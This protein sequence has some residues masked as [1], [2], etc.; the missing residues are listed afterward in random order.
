M[1]SVLTSPPACQ[2][3]EADFFQAVVSAATGRIDPRLV[4]GYQAAAPGVRTDVDSLGGFLAPNTFTDR[5]ITKAYNTGEILKRCLEL[6]TAGRNKVF[7]PVISE[8]SR[9]NG[10]RFGGMT[11]YRVDEAGTFSDSKPAVGGQWRVLHK[12]AGLIYA[13]NEMLEDYP[14]LLPGYLEFVAGSELAYRAE[15]DIVNGDGAA[16]A[17][18][19]I[20]APCRI[21]I[22]KETNQPAATVQGENISKMLARFW[23]PSQRKGVWLYN[24][25]LLPTLSQLV[26]EAGYGS[27]TVAV[28]APL[29]NWDGNAKS[30]GWPT[31]A[32]MP[33]I[34][35]E[36]C[37]APGTEGDLIL[38]DLSQ[39]GI[40][41]KQR[42]AVSTH[43]Q[44][45]TD[46]AC[47]RFVWSFD[48]APLW[49]GPLTPDNG[50]DTLSPI[51]TLETRS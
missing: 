16:K 37:R 4:P 23:G 27:G 19:L 38:T 12:L 10:S 21:T 32:G 8:S 1:S 2:M 44:F 13:T 28:E 31:L 49:A 50:T 40:A 48:G 6:E 30:G 41:L 20:N 47:F 26:I 25:G 34:P 14:E 22:S 29:W 7:T 5:V 51:V 46:Q 39:Y 17:L 42:F 35:V 24:Q 33:A 45:L 3:D 11:V 43:V 18:G 9:G 15:D 36:S